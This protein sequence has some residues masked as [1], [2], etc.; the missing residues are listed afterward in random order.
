MAQLLVKLVQPGT[1]RSDDPPPERAAENPAASFCATGPLLVTLGAALFAVTNAAS[2]GLYR[3]GGTVV[4]LYL[5]RA[6]VVYAANG[7][8]TSARDGHAEACRVLQ[9]RTGK[10]ETSRLAVARGLV[11]AAMALLLNLAFLLLT[12]NDAFTVFKGVDMLATVVLSRALLGAAE[13]LSPAE[14]A[15]GML[16]LSGIVLVAQPSMLGVSRDGAAAASTAAGAAAAGAAAAGAAAGTEAVVSV[17]GV[18][19]AGVEGVVG[20]S[21]A[22]VAVAAMAG[23]LSACSGVSTRALSA[24]DGPHAG[25]APPAML[26]SYL[27]VTMG[28]CFGAIAIGAHAS[29]L[30]ALPRWSWSALAWPSTSVDWALICVHCSCVLAA[31]AYPYP[32]PYP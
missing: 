18:S 2:T 22:G 23:V 4:T 20:V 26:L 14:L 17:A 1:A 27:L 5:I 32:Y 13:R 24:R 29:H 25:H 8:L 6:V 9:L 15:C 10:V 28:A 21:A 31:Q 16:T 7:A 19:A 3:R 12:F 11:T 30:D